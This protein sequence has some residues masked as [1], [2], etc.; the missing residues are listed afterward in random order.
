MNPITTEYLGSRLNLGLDA[1]DVVR[2]VVC[3]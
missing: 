2:V 3:G 1:Q